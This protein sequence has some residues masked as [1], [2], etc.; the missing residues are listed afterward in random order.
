MHKMSLE[1]AEKAAEK[2]EGYLSLP[3]GRLLYKLARNHNVGGAIVEV[4]SWK[5]KSTIWLA[6]GSKAGKKGKVF[7]IDPHTGSPEMP[8][9]N[10]LK[11]FSQ[12]IKKAGVADLVKPIVKTSEQ[13][14]ALFK[15]E[16]GLVFI[17]GR[18]EYSFAKQDFE[19]WFPKVKQHGVMVFHDTNLAV[20]PKKVVKE[21]VFDSKNFRNIGFLDS[22]TF[23]EKVKQNSFFDRLQNRKVWLL[24][25]FFTLASKLNLKIALPKPI[26]AVGKKLIELMQ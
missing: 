5:G 26:K 14:A 21:N 9:G 22:I 16:V 24:K 8:K 2:A 23:A 19:L 12:N 3:E 25:Q 11:E 7:A 18:H 17:D 15:G 20:G 13:A 4:G 1:M 6:Y 10:S